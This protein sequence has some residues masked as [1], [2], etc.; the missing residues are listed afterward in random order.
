M[1]EGESVIGAE[2]L[3][4]VAESEAT[5]TTAEIFADIKV[6]L[7][8]G[9]VNLVYRHLATAPAAL[10]WAWCSVRPLVVD[11]TVDAAARQM[12]S[13]VETGQ[14]VDELIS[15][16]PRSVLAAARDSDDIRRVLHSYN[17]ANPQNL[18]IVLGLQ[19]LLRDA[20]RD[21]AIPARFSATQRAESA[22]PVAALPPMIDPGQLD[23]ALVELISAL[24]VDRPGRREPVL[25]P[26]LY[27]HLARWPDFLLSVLTVLASPS[28]LGHLTSTQASLET[29]ARACAQA[30]IAADR[31]HDPS[32]YAP[33]PRPELVSQQLARFANG[34]IARMILVGQVLA[35]YLD[36]SPRST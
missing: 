19:A 29:R 3:A 36:S 26:S 17:H 10:E 24:S 13:S 8:V 22:E 9:T 35:S 18:I 34:T 1:E 21:A 14:I 28:S 6:C 30:L 11:G 2:P 33:P 7:E 15:R 16:I 20:A 32:R 23:P 5:G 25:V 4:E 12:V 31:G 27:R